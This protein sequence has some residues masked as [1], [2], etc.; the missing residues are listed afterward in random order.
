MHKNMPNIPIYKDG[1]NRND[2]VLGQ[3]VLCGCSTSH[4]LCLTTLIKTASLPDVKFISQ[5]SF[6][7][8]VKI[9]CDSAVLFLGE[10]K[11]HLTK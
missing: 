1:N 8:P 2:C 6:I 11:S 9:Q 3:N 5:Y 4:D 10:E 7:H